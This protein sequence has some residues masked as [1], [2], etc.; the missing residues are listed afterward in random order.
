MWY[1]SEASRGIK[2]FFRRAMREKNATTGGGW[3]YPRRDF[4]P[5]GNIVTAKKNL[6]LLKFPE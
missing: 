1:L 6:A 2:F 3:R 4:S 5:A